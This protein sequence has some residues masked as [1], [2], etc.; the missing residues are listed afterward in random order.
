[1]GHV[2]RENRMGR[3]VRLSAEVE[4]LPHATGRMG[5]WQAEG[6]EVL[7]I[8][9]S[10]FHEVCNFMLVLS[11][12]CSVLSVQRQVCFESRQE[13]I[14]HADG[15][16]SCKENQCPVMQGDMMTF[17]DWRL[18]VIV[19]C[20]LNATDE[21]CCQMKKLHAC[22]PTRVPLNVLWG[23]VRL[24]VEGCGLGSSLLARDAELLGN[25]RKSPDRTRRMLAHGVSEQRT[26]SV[27]RLE[28]FGKCTGPSAR[29]GRGWC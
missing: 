25:S 19:A 9:G 27:A 8:L 28:R 26:S 23:W 24:R 21:G 29:L 6:I 12:R 3:F 11:A 7:L 13:W 1:M 2:R 16:L 15:C 14:F 20:L 10:H 4:E 22:F 17:C 18:V 5:L